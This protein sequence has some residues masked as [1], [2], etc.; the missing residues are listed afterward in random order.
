MLGTRPLATTSIATRSISDIFGGCVHVAITA[1]V[2]VVSLS[3]AFSTVTL[4]NAFSTVTIANAFST[5]V[6]TAASAVV[7]ILNCA[8]DE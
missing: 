7:Q 4:T 6:K 1:A 3:N 8:K 5:V 2:A